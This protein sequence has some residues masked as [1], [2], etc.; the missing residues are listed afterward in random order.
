MRAIAGQGLLVTIESIQ[1]DSRVPC[2][3][4]A[5]VKTVGADRRFETSRGTVR[6]GQ[7]FIALMRTSKAA[8]F[9]PADFN[10]S[11]KEMWLEGLAA[12]GQVVSLD[13]VAIVND[14]ELEFSTFERTMEIAA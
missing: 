5:I 6:A 2:D 3:M 12:S 8:G 11:V 4:Y 13:G 10:R 1:G 9:P 7:T 14:D